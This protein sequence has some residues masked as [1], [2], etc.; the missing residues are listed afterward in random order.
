MNHIDTARPSPIAGSWYP[1]DLN[2][3][4]N[5]IANYISKAEINILKEKVIGLISP[6]A[7][8]IYSAETAGYAYRCV[9]GYSYDLVVVAS[10]MHA[11]HPYPF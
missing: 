4:R 10:P 11:Y 3:L 6:H 2:S 5:D 1:G 8:Y 7:G 9:E